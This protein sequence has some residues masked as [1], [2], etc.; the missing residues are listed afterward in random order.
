MIK[1]VDNII[2]VPVEKIIEK[3]VITMVEK[4]IEVKKILERIVEKEDRSKIIK[5][6]NDLL[7]L[8]KVQNKV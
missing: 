4:F 7:A 5:L 2:E 3:P 1:T 6:E 8:E